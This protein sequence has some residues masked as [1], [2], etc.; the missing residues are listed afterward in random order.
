MQEIF[1]SF[2]AAIARKFIYNCYRDL[3]L[4]LKRVTILISAKQ[5]RDIYAVCNHLQSAGGVCSVL[6]GVADT[7]PR[8]KTSGA[9]FPVAG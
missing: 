7:L 1:I 3:Y 5:P 8:I 9:I 6:A 2:V 4:R